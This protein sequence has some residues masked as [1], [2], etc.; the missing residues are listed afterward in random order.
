MAGCSAQPPARATQPTAQ[1]SGAA[2]PL[3]RAPGAT[4]APSP[5]AQPA[6]PQTQATPR[7]TSPPTPTL[8]PAEG[9]VASWPSQRT[10]LLPG[11][12]AEGQL[13]QGDG[14]LLDGTLFD[15]YVFAGKPGQFATLDL[16]SA[17]F[18]AYLVLVDPLGRIMATND[19]AAPKAGRGARIAVGLPTQGTY[20]VWV[21]SNAGS[22]GAYTLRLDLED[23][24]EK[25]TEL[26]VG[27]SGRGWLMPGDQ[28]NR[29]G[30]YVDRWSIRMP[31][32]PALV[33]LTSEEFDTYLRALAPDGAPLIDNDDINFVA[34]DSNSRVVLAPSERAPAGTP[35]T[36]EVSMPNP[37]PQA[38][39][40]RIEVSPLPKEYGPPA[41]V[42]V[43]PLIVKSAGGGSQVTPEQVRTA[44]ARASQIW[45]ACNLA[46]ALDG[47]GVQTVQIDALGAQLRA[48]ASTW[49]DDET[50]LQRD[51]SHAPYDEGVVTVY[52]VRSIDGGERYGIAYPSTR[53]PAT[54]SGLVAVSDDAA[55]S[56]AHFAATL[57]HEIGHILGLEHPNALT[58]D[59]DPWND[60]PA[61]LMGE[62]AAGADLTPLQ[63][64]TARGDDHYLRP[65]GGALPAF[66]HTQR[67]LSL[68]EQVRG[69]LTNRSAELPDGQRIEV[70]YFYGRR[71]DQI[72]LELASDAFDPVLTVDGP[73]DTQ[74]GQDD[75]GGGGTQA[76]L[77]LTLP[78]T[79]DYA[80]GVS[81]AAPGAGAFTLSLR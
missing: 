76:R 37:S 6:R 74:I 77:A 78:A 71:G 49:T 16:G 14:V 36:L 56:P 34:G 20:Q 60:T 8:A 9:E 31:D 42:T 79:G 22:Q 24:T 30:I 46:V 25:D 70:Y 65:Q 17:V 45:S 23:R 26:R 80:V 69:A 2:A 39:A 59:G 54:R 72:T 18:D 63:C 7:P 19:D 38:G 11:R 29:F 52:F 50:L 10:P 58:G 35:V 81:S 66:R 61:N 51:P 15:L 68:G 13:A 28:V 41:T 33:W 62:Q 12:P 4:P 21:N 27:A 32:E 1:P 57:A 67:V 48:G 53:Y 3:V 64:L 73:D 55:D 43:R 75:D 47:A 44:V 5:A 40:Y